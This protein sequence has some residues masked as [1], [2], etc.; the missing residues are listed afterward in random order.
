MIRCKWP[1]KCRKCGSERYGEYKNKA[2]NR[3]DRHCLDCKAAWIKKD[4]AQNT[5][6]YRRQARERML[7]K[8]YNIT[9]EE[10]EYRLSAQNN[11]CAICDKHRSAFKQTLAVD[12]CHKTGKVRGILCSNCN[13]GIGNMKDNIEFLKKAI[14]YLTEE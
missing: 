5:V 11:R 6:M 12:H 9:D 8:T 7:K 13:L 14:G 1:Y 4:R 3:I 2:K 10:Y